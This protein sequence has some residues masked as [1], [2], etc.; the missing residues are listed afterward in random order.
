VSESDL[1]AVRVAA[2]SEADFQDDGH[3]ASLIG[4]MRRARTAGHST[5]EIAEAAGRTVEQ[6]SEAPV[7]AAF[8]PPGNASRSLIGGG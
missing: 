2:A 1:I 7:Q 5:E 4:W 3:L 6:A 8:L